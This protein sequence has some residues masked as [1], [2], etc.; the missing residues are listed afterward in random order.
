MKKL[1]PILIISLLFLLFGCSTSEK[2]SNKKSQIE[3]NKELQKEYD[4]MNL[5]EMDNGL[6]TEKFSDEP[7]SGKVF[8]Y[9]GEVQPLKKVYMGNLRNGKKE[10]KWVSYYHS[11]GK[12]SFEYNFKNGKE[13]GLFTYWGEYGQKMG[14]GNYKDG[15][16]DGLCTRWYKNGQKWTEATYKDGKVDGLYSEWYINGQKRMRE[17][18]KDGKVNGLRTL[19][20]ENG[21]KSSERTYKDGELI[22]EECLDEDGNECECH[23]VYWKGCK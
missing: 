15:K 11:T 2:Q 9:F 22:S 17:T 19:W 16:K 21:Q 14:E 8:G 3:H 5:I 1:Y 23:E 12:K 4:F 18:F 10:G 13:D 7:I 6:W 20:Y